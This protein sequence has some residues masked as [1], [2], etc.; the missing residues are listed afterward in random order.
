VPTGN[1]GNAL[2]CIM[3][4]EMG[5]PIGRVTLAT[6]AN[7]TLPDYFGGREFTPR[8]ALATLANAMD[9]GNPSNFERLAWL[10]RDGDLRE[11]GIDAV[12]VD[13]E[14]IRETIKRTDRER[15]LAI[16]PHTACAMAAYEDR[17]KA[18]ETRPTLLV[19]TAHPAKFEQVVEPLLGREIDPPLALAELLRKDSHAEP[20]AAEYEALLGVLD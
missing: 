18:G 12:A 11:S 17:L 2:A 16:C 10:F 5:L 4:R 19:A 6:N 3:A 15:D 1:L 13:D 9:V 20:M 14:R 7:A 8:E